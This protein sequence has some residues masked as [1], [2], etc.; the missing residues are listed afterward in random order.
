GQISQNEWLQIA[1]I[2]GGAQYQ[3]NPAGDDYTVANPTLSQDQIGQ[4]I[5]ML[6]TFMN[7]VQPG[8][9]SYKAL[10]QQIT[11]LG[12]QMGN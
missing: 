8:T 6:N 9:G 5:Q 2:L 4:R 3:L 11:T 7:F 1:P 12:A 10:Q